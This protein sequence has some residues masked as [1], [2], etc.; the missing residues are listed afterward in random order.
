MRFYSVIVQSHVYYYEDYKEKRDDL[1]WYSNAMICVF[2]GIEEYNFQM[3]T[4][5]LRISRWIR[6]D[7]VSSAKKVFMNLDGNWKKKMKNCN[8][9]V[10]LAV[11]AILQWY[12]T[13]LWF[14][15]DI[16][17]SSS[18]LQTSDLTLEINQLT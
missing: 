11:N 17:T 18:A 15:T 4:I 1:L 14:Y 13:N 12:K 16:D 10:F 7:V 2:D 3:Y 5:A 6:A 8:N 9:C